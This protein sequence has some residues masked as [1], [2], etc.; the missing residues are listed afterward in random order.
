[1][2]RVEVYEHFNRLRA[3]AFGIAERIKSE[4]MTDTQRFA[5][6]LRF[7]GLAKMSADACAEVLPP[8]EAH[9]LA[10]LSAGTT[11]PITPEQVDAAMDTELGRRMKAACA[12]VYGKQNLNGPIPVN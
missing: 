4:P 6:L 7:Q 11:D 8:V 5:L 10:E 2:T 1:M 3:E 9:L 12:I